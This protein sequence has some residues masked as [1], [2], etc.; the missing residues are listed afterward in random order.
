M[1]PKAGEGMFECYRESDDSRWLCE[2]RDH[3]K[4]Y[5]Y[6]AQFRLETFTP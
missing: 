2:L 5:G 3:G 6:E 1:Q 4:E